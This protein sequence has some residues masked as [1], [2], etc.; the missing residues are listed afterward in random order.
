M[1]HHQRRHQRRATLTLDEVIDD[2][3]VPEEARRGALPPRR[4]AVEGARRRDLLRRQRHVVRVRKVEL[5][6]RERRVQKLEVAVLVALLHRRQAA[7][8]RENGDQR[9]PRRL[10]KVDVGESG[11][12]RVGRHDQRDERA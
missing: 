7:A 2:L 11:E 1:Q 12:P 4:S 3:A 6:L 5:V 8:R 10:A 9:D